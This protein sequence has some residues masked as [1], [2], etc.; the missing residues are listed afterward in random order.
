MTKEAQK[1]IWKSLGITLALGVAAL[2]VGIWVHYSGLKRR[3]FL[4]EL[5]ALVFGGLAIGMALFKMVK[6]RKFLKSIDS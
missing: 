1:K 4:L 3:L 6:F 2:L 5:C